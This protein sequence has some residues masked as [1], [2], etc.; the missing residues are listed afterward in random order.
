MWMLHKGTQQNFMTSYQHEVNPPTIV[1]TFKVISISRI[2]LHVSKYGEKRNNNR[3]VKT[4]K[5]NHN[6][7]NFNNLDLL[8]LPYSQL[9]AIRSHDPSTPFIFIEG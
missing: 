1:A 2:E 6:N 4:T 7:K 8:L 9:I 3:S 5:L